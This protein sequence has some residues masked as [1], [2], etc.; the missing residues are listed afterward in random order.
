MTDAI[1]I[2]VKGKDVWL[3]FASPSGK[4]ASL[5]VAALAD[6]RGPITGAALRE[7]AAD[8]IEKAKHIHVGPDDACA[9]CGRDIRDLIHVRHTS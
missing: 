1:E 6:A 9:K 4:S 2:S 7:W 8:Q 3:T 5:S